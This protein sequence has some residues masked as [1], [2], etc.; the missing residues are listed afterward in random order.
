[1]VDG[2]PSLGAPVHASIDGTVTAIQNGVL[3]IL[4]PNP[5]PLI[6]NP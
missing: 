4:A 3:W 2:R 5:Q 6:P 1:M